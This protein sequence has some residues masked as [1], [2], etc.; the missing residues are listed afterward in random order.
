[1]PHCTFCLKSVPTL[2]ERCPHCAAWL[3]QNDGSEKPQEPAAEPID[4]SFESEIRS[5][6]SQNRKIEAIKIYRERT[7]VGLAEANY[8]V[9]LL[10]RGGSLNE[11]PMSDDVDPQLLEL[12]M[13][14]QKI[15]AIKLYREKTNLGLKESKEAVEAIAARQGIAPQHVGCFGVLVVIIVVTTAVRFFG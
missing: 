15:K 10:Q 2:A 9:E 6:L 13:A 7:G 1:M 14:G 8:A 4:E 3:N 12:L 5:L 11:P